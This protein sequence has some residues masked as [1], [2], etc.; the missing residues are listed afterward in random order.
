MGFTSHRQYLGTPT[1][2]SCHPGR[3]MEEHLLT[4]NI[5]LD[6]ATAAGN[7][8]WI[9][10]LDLSKAFDRVHWPALWVALHDQG[11]SEHCIWLL[12]IREV[13]GQWGRSLELYN[14][15]RRETKV[16]LEAKIFQRYIGVGSAWLERSI[17]RGRNWFEGRAALCTWYPTLCKLWPG[18]CAT[19][20][21][22]INCCS[23][24]QWTDSK[25]SWNGTRNQ[26]SATTR[27]T[28]DKGCCGQSTPS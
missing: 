5:L 24:A 27:N 20:G 16:C 28:C 2:W 23:W 4:T 3:R 15:S 10:S 6:T 21:Q 11:A 22:F 17:P 25:C 18:S 8:I 14:R 1:A 7:T 12:Q 9:V 13:M 26:S 19:S